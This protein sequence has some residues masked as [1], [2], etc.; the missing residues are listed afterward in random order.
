MFHSSG[1]KYFNLQPQW[2]SHFQDGLF[3]NEKGWAPYLPPALND[4]MLAS[5]SLPHI[6]KGR[7]DSIGPASC[8]GL[9]LATQSYR[10][11]EE[12]HTL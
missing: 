5:C 3:N 10:E 1:L 2:T 11:N 8:Q 4:P 7:L 12:S 6:D 9:S